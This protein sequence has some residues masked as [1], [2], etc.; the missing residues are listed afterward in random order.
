MTFM[1]VVRWSPDGRH[2]VVKGFEGSQDVRLDLVDMKSGA[3]K[4]ILIKDEDFGWPLW[5]PTADASTSSW[6]IP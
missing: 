3:T 6:G 2:A 4:K 5:N 1:S